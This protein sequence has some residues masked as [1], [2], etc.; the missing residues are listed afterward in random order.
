[1]DIKKYIFTKSTSAFRKKN[2]RGGCFFGVIV[3][4]VDKHLMVSDLKI[5][6]SNI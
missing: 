4:R 6:S 2:E 3:K 1:M 5:F